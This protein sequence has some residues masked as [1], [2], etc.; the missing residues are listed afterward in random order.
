MKKIFSTIVCL[1]FLGGAIAQ[2]RQKVTMIPLPKENKPSKADTV[3]T[4]IGSQP[5]SKLASNT[6]VVPKVLVSAANVDSSLPYRHVPLAGEYE[7]FGEKTDFVNDFVRK[8]MAQ[9]NQTLSSVKNNSSTPF[10]VIDNILEEKKMPKELKYL[11]VI[12]SALNHNA[13]SHAGAVGPCQLM[14]ATAK[15]MGLTVTRKNDERRDWEKSTDAATKYLDFLYSQLN[16]W[17]LVIAAYNC[18]P[19]PVQKA[20]AKTGSHSFW[21]IKEYLP[22]E[23]QGHVLAFIAT[24]SIFENLGKFINL[25]SIPLDFNFGKQADEELEVK[26]IPL[27]AGV[28]SDTRKPTLTED[29]IRNMVIMRINDPINPDMLAQELGL[30]KKSIL[31]MNPEYESFILK[32]YATPYYN[33]HLPKEKLDAF[34]QKKADLT[35]RSKAYYAENQF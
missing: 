22:R 19:T 32:K 16:D 34:L 28:V 17:L 27:K 4:M 10:S 33:L 30:D 12:E 3:I 1:L 31:K 11:A 15:M 5:N 26:E 20:L 35:K 14:S 29:E 13:V 9:H 24:A 25:G 18:G 21:D 7:Y 2:P 23:T 8:Y 6:E